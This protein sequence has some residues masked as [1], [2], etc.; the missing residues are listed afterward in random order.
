MVGQSRFDADN[1][2]RLI[3]CRAVQAMRPVYVVYLPMAQVTLYL[4]D[5]IAGRLKKAATK[6]GQSVSGFVAALAERELSPGRW[7]TSFERL[8]GEWEGDFI[9]GPDGPPDHVELP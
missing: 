2:Q 4:P 3:F 7:P 8:Y 1:A 9:V 5:K 6:A